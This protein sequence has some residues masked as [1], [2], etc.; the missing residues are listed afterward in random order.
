MPLKILMVGLGSIGQ[1][2][3]RNFTSLYGH[4][5]RIL[6]Y[7]VRGLQRTFSADMKIRKG[8]NLESEYNIQ[9]FGDLEL[10]LKERPDIAFITNITS[11]HISCA[12]AAAKAGCDLFLEKP[13]SHS[14]EGID[15]LSELVSSKG[16]IAFVGF[17]N[18]Y[19]PCIVMAKKY[20]EERVLGNVISVD[21]EMGERIET[22]HSY[23]NYS[24]TYMARRDMGGGVVL[25]QEIHELDYIQWLFGVPD[26]VYSVGGNSGSLNIDVED[27]CTSIYKVRAGGRT[28]PIV[29]HADFFQSPTSR[30]CKIVGEHGQIEFDLL[31]PSISLCL[32]GEK[33]QTTKFDQFQRNDMF[34]AELKDFMESVST[35]KAPAIPLCAGIY[36]MRMA[37]AAKKS[38]EDRRIVRLEEIL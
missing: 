30:R 31:N 10:A 33:T 2:H 26:D 15:V 23:E 13:L 4:K 21:V 29:V 14:M 37:L 27:N 19:H 5:H 16:L 25:N 18:R 11:E 35:R 1:R 34:M 7:R 24:S 36:S 32:H 8:V 9:S 22:M 12:I 3:L 17:Q 20:L 28:I 38:F 6:A